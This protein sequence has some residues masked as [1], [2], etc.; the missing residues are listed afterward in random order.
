MNTVD[1]FEYLGELITILNKEE[2][3][4]KVHENINKRVNDLIEEYGLTERAL[5]SLYEYASM[6]E[7]RKVKLPDKFSISSKKD[8]VSPFFDFSVVVKS[9]PNIALSVQAEALCD[10]K[11]S[12]CKN[13]D[14]LS[15]GG[16]I[17]YVLTDDQKFAQKNCQ[18]GSSYIDNFDRAA[19]IALEKKIDTDFFYFILDKT[20]WTYRIASLRTLDKVYLNQTGQNFLQ[21]TWRKKMKRVERDTNQ[22]I[23]W[24]RPSVEDAKVNK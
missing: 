2:V 1:G 12:E 17:L 23:D 11:A 6:Q 14:N 5:S 15:A 22:F 10:H 13:N 4:T 18:L 16:A 21:A 7:I 19:K 24:I 9:D 20:A 3:G 8:T